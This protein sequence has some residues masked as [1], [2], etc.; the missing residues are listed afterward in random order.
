[1]FN[2]WFCNVHL[3]TR[4]ATLPSR[5]WSFPGEQR[6]RW[7]RDTDG[8]CGAS[9]ELRH[10][11][12]TGGLVSTIYKVSPCFSFTCQHMATDCFNS[13]VIISAFLFLQWANLTWAKT[14]SGSASVEFGAAQLAKPK[15]QKTQRSRSPLRSHGVSWWTAWQTVMV[16]VKMRQRECSPWQLCAPIGVSLN[17]GTEFPTPIRRLRG[18]GNI[19]VSNAVPW[20][21]AVHGVEYVQNSGT[22]WKNVH[23]RVENKTHEIPIP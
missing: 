15:T 16:H 13:F 6:E 14:G 20:T 22:G 12:Q 5:L 9:S 3:R 10:Q 11:R 18:Q 7:P 8:V 1:M 19:Q 4:H 2:P 23:N 21:D 17:F